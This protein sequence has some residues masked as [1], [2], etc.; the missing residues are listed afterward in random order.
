MTETEKEEVSVKGFFRE[1]ADLGRTTD[2]ESRGLDCVFLTH[3]S[4]DQRKHA[5]TVTP[6]VFSGV[7][8]PS[9]TEPTPTTG[10][11]APPSGMPKVLEVYRSSGCTVDPSSGTVVGTVRQY[12]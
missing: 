3:K 4:T 10:E 6:G 8:R 1:G 12:P 11:G 9:V 5:Q 2:G 7:P